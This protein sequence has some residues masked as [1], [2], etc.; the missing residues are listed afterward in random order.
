M[1]YHLFW[2]GEC[3]YKKCLAH[4]LVNAYIQQRLPS[5]Q[6]VLEDKLEESWHYGNIRLETGKQ[7]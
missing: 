6:T 3:I 2:A 5:K 7:N 4:D 1:Y